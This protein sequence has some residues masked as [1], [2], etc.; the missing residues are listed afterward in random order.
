MEEEEGT[1]EGSFCL[2]A[3]ELVSTI[4]AW[5]PDESLFICSFVCKRWHALFRLLS[6]MTSPSFFCKAAMAGH[7]TVLKWA[8][9]HGCPLDNR[10]CNWAA[11]GGQL[12]VLQWARENEC[13]WNGTVE[14]Y[15]AP[16]RGG[17]KWE[18]ERGGLA[19]GTCAQVQHAQPPS[20]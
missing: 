3:S 16:V 18:R 8:R 20:T 4:F 5:L 19:R 12:H 15:D 17:T 11:R 14:D 2:L 10:T 9:E 13:P 7:L 6:S 1:G